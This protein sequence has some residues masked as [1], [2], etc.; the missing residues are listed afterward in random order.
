MLNIIAAVAQNG[1]I[2]KDGNLPFSLKEDMARFKSLTLHN[3]VIMGKN[4]FLSIGA[5]LKNR[6]NIIVSSTLK[7][8][9]GAYIVKSLADALTLAKSI[10]PDKDVFAIGGQ[11]IYN[12][13]LMLADKLYI[14]LVDVCPEGDVYFPSIPN[15]F[16]LISSAPVSDSGLDTRFNVYERITD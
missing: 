10:A 15:S 14:T 13:C 1:V 11:S 12:E 7:S 3:V 4:T 9:D 6:I 8:A 16:R 5:P 2:G